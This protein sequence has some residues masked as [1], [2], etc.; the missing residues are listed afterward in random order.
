MLE[1]L[2]KKKEEQL[3]TADYIE[4]SEEELNSLCKADA[5]KIESY[6]HG[7]TLMKL[8]EF[9]R[10]FFE[11]VRKIDLPVWEDLWDE[12]DDPYFVSIDFLHHFV[13][14]GNGFPICDLVDVENYWFTERHIK[15]K[16]IAKF[17]LIDQK[18]QEKRPLTVIEALLCEIIKSSID[19]WHF[20]YRY[21]IPLSN[22]KKEVLIM[23]KDDL[24]VHLTNRDDLV[25][26]LDI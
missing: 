8:P 24:L 11:W 9:E 6:F 2:I 13:D 1:E 20:C 26:Y 14:H 12:E 10:K 5:R 22:A 16:G 21:N 4:F 23:H 3:L 7:H 19:I 25:K 17:E 18:I 15:P